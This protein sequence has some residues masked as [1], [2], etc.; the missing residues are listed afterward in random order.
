MKHII[1]CSAIPETVQ[2][3]LCVAAIR[4]T[5]DAM[6]TPEGR[7]AVE[8]GRQEYLRHMAEVEGRNAVE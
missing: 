5:M 6:K 7:A 8:K 2:V 3:D 1:D 4:G